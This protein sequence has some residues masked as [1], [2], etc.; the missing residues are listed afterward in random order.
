MS[1]F[2]F[3]MYRLLSY[4]IDIILTSSEHETSME[5]IGNS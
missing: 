2:S 3:L 1:N 4:A 5:I